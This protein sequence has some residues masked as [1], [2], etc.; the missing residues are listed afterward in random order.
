MS[1]KKAP[2][3]ALVLSLCLNYRNGPR[4]D[5]PVYGIHKWLKFS[6]YL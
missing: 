2:K 5:S 6:G 4:I 1:K 3:G